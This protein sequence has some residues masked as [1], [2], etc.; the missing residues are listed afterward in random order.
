[1]LTD[2]NRTTIAAAEI[3]STYIKCHRIIFSIAFAVG[4]MKLFSERHR[5]FARFR[6]LTIC[7]TYS[8]QHVKPPCLGLSHAISR[9]YQF[10]LRPSSP[11][12]A[13]PQPVDFPSHSQLHSLCSGPACG[14]RMSFE[15]IRNAYDASGVFSRF[16][17]NANNLHTVCLAF[18]V[19]TEWSHS[20][21]S[22][23]SISVHFTYTC[24]NGATLCVAVSISCKESQL[25]N[26]A[27]Q[28]S[29]EK[30][31]ESESEKYKCQKLNAQ[32]QLSDLLKLDSL[33][34]FLYFG[35]SPNKFER[36]K[37]AIFIVKIRF[38]LS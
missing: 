6:S 17:K 10:H 38:K 8:W 5:V 24:T 3:R 34:L 32:M 27:S 1:M 13:S 29:A 21:K 19:H 7:S 15:L 26:H 25:A 37:S 14:L 31:E 23:S 33:S 11:P 30:V 18:G 9:L 22:P 4:P 28:D 36:G 20:E 12:T 35:P 16:H 2:L